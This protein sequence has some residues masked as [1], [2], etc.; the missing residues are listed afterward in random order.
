MSD[1][2]LTLSDFC[3]PSSVGMVAIHSALRLSD[4]YWIFLLYP[5]FPPYG[6]PFSI[7]PAEVL[8]FL[9]LFGSRDNER[10]R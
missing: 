3:A 1:E 7:A 9:S 8:S 2:N 4:F 6:Y 5:V 10:W